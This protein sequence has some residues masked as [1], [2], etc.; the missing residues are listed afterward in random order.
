MEANEQKLPGLF[1]LKCVRIRYKK[2]Y[3]KT[4]SAGKTSY[5]IL[6][7]QINFL[8]KEER[9]QGFYFYIYSKITWMTTKNLMHFLMKL[10]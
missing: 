1:L 5:N 4:K 3:T 7:A 6:E 2:P 8:F 9:S 10:Q